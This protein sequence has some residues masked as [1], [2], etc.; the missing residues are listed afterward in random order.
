[1][2]GPASVSKAF[3]PA[4]A[5]LPDAGA[6]RAQ[7]GGGGLSYSYY[8]AQLAKYVC[9]L[10][11]AIGECKVLDVGC[12]EARLAGL[13]NR[14][15]PGSSV[16]GVDAFIRPRRERGIGIIRA[17]GTTLP[18]GDDAFDVALVLNVLHHANRPRE[19]LRE[20]CRVA[21]SRVVIKDHVAASWLQHRQL[22]L[23]DVLGNAGTGAVVRG[24]YLSNRGWAELFESFP[25]AQTA[26][27]KGLAMRQGWLKTLF[28]NTLEVMF[29]LDL[30]VPPTAS[31]DINRNASL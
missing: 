24:R 4:P 17:D 26:E 18:F 25:G 14:S 9:S 12:G 27:Y 11:P 22:E 19:L 10:L 21:R 2:L 6:L 8:R 29:T 15:R 20:V 3:P 1:M 7:L 28:P 13:I 31:D 16:V 30:A 23:L 5:W